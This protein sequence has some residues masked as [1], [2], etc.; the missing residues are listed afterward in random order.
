MHEIL[1]FLVRHGYF[2]LF[3]A[4]L[5][6]QGGLPIPSS[7]FLLAAGA[8]AGTGHLRFSLAI[9]FAVLACVISDNLWF[10]LGRRRG[11][12]MLHFLCR[13]SLEP[14]SCV[15]RTENVFTRYGGRYLLVAKFIPGL[16]GIS[17]PLAG[18]FKMPTSRFMLLDGLG[19][20]LWA[21]AFTSLGYLFTN[22]LE[23]VA[24]YAASFGGSLL[25]VIIAA[26]GCFVVWK[27]FNRRRFLRKLRISRITP[28]ELKSKLDASEDLLVID[29]RHSRDFEAEPEGIPGSVHITTEE[30]SILQQEIPRDKDIILY[31][32]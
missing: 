10:Y 32:H 28:E 19:S 29:V 13:I 11:N 20:L 9:G 2:A 15:R 21:G 5:L 27:Y 23:D 18:V 30:F 7:P 24:R 12:K 25:V 14:D 22:Q 31:C 26:L 4:V 17:A 1:Q 16:G 6:E 3:A 8:Y